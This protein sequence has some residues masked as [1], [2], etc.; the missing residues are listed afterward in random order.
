MDDCILHGRL[1]Y[2]NAYPTWMNALECLL[3]KET[4]LHD[5]QSISLIGMHVLHT[6]N[7]CPTWMPVQ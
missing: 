4:V 7:T 3:F 6:L 5:S 1:S 2:M